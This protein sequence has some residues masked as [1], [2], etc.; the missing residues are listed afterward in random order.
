[1]VKLKNAKRIIFES[2]NQQTFMPVFQYN[3]FY[4]HNRKAM[5]KAI[6]SLIVLL[7]SLINLNA[8]EEG[9]LKLKIEI[10]ILFES[11]E[12]SYFLSGAFFNLEPKLKISK[13]KVI[14]LRI[15]AASNSQ[16]ILT[17]DP[18]RFFVNN[19]NDNSGNTAIS[20]IPTFDYYLNNKNIRPYLG[21]GIG[22]YILNTSKEGFFMTN[23]FDGQELSINNK[24]GFLV[25]SG[26]D[27]GKFIVWGF[28]FSKF[29]VG[30]EFNY[31]PKTDVELS[32]G[33]LIGTTE[34]SNIAISIGYTISSEKKSK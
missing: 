1:M 34:N 11:V 18:N 12:G 13:N 8:Q 27:L 26:F 30:L 31:I 3:I 21:F 5:L 19:E 29:S 24:I 28:D 7:L 9:D 17:I 32:D 33:E 25:R 16:S 22:Y 10:G 23:L 2:I 15:G 4:P 20:F 14:G 6:I